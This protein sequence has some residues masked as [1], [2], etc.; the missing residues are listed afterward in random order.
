MAGMIEMI[1]DANPGRNYKN[2]NRRLMKLFEELGEVSEAYLN[3]TSGFNGKNKTWD[4]IREEIVDVLIMTVD[5]ALT[6][7]PGVPEHDFSSLN[8]FSNL[9]CGLYDFD[10]FEDFFMEICKDGSDAY[11]T[12]KIRPDFTTSISPEYREE[13]KT[14]IEVA[15]KYAPMATDYVEANRLVISAAINAIRLSCVRFPDQENKTVDE[16]DAAL[17][18]ELQRKLDKWAAKRAKMECPTDDI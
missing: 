4:D 12:L 1:R 6:P 7:L 15:T 10:A 14:L 11:D 17:I 18:V 13:H 8:T 5:I 16:L 2:L 3:V 9:V